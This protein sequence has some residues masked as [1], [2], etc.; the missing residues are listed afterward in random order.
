MTKE[1]RDALNSL[2]ETAK[3]TIRYAGVIGDYEVPL[4]TRRNIGTIQR[5]IRA[6]LIAV[7]ADL[8]LSAFVI[9]LQTEIGPQVTAL[10]MRTLLEKNA[11]PKLPRILADEMAI[12]LSTDGNVYFEEVLSDLESVPDPVIEVEE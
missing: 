10:E 4:K 3:Y 9:E 6:K 7:E 12:C 11:R 2:P 8:K 1:F 5:I